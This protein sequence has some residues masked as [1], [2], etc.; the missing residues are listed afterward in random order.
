M[1]E[2]HEEAEA[3]L[4]RERTELNAAITDVATRLSIAVEGLEEIA[5]DD[6]DAEPDERPEPVDERQKIARRTLYRIKGE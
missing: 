3:R 4:S 6:W 1:S 5:G 2:T